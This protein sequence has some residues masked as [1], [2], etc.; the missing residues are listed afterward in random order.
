MNVRRLDLLN[1]IFRSDLKFQDVDARVP[2]LA[3]TSLKLMA[4]WRNKIADGTRRSAPYFQGSWPDGRSFSFAS[5]SLELM[6]VQRVI[7][8][9][10][11]HIANVKPSNP[12]CLR[13]DMLLLFMVGS[14]P[15]LRDITSFTEKSAGSVRD[16][17][18]IDHGDI[19][20][21]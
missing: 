10:R 16:F 14:Q 18:A 20:S 13:Q 11:W 5:I 4:V 12:S 9:K 3:D 21:Q 17:H 15:I 8:F 19:V 7:L 2:S 1:D 6:V